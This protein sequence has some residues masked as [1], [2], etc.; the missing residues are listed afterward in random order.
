MPKTGTIAIGWSEAAEKAAQAEGQEQD[1][2]EGGDL[3]GPV[4]VTQ[5]V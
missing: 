3:E 4:Q 2:K 1:D 5:M